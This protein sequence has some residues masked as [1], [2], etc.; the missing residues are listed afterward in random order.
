MAAE[1][2]A[3][4][5]VERY[6]YLRCTSLPKV[7][8]GSKED[9]AKEGQGRLQGKKEPEEPRKA[10]RPERRQGTGTQ[11]GTRLCNWSLLLIRNGDFR[12]ES[13]LPWRGYS[14]GVYA[15]WRYA[16]LPIAR[17]CARFLLGDL[18]LIIENY[19]SPGL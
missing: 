15:T 9:Q 2:P 6:Y 11:K 4:S 1:L 3:T 5:V 7:K 16:T 17:S 10:G 19:L 18:S 13:T 12:L 14:T 8:R